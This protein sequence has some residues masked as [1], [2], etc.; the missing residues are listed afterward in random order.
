MQVISITATDEPIN[1]A[2]C[3]VCANEGLIDTW[4]P[5]LDEVLMREVW[6]EDHCLCRYG[7]RLEEL[8]M[9]MTAVAEEL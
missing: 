8:H 5:E 4:H 3:P 2:D 1:P 6:L 7:R 9:D